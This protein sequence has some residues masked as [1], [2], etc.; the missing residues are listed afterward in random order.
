MT[1]GAYDGTNVRLN[2][3][4]SNNLKNWKKQGRAFKNFRFIRDGGVFVRWHN[5]KLIESHEIKN[6]DEMSKAGGIFPE[7]INGKYWMLFNEHRI[8]IANSDDG[9]HWEALP[10]PFLGPRKGD[11]FDNL[12]I[13]MGPPPIKT[14]QGWLVFYHGIDGAVVYCLGCLLLDL[15]DPT[16]ILYRSNNAIFSPKEKYELSG[17]VDILPGGLDRIHRMNDKKIKLFLKNAKKNKLMPKVTFCSAA[18]VVDN[19]I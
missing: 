18:V 5:G 15:K 14:K 1:Y 10:G 13:E 9:I 3:A 8:W 12:F 4:T 11:Y 6:N 2:V 19:A 16:K 17:F 7:L